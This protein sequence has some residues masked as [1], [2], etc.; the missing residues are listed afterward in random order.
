[1]N[2]VFNPSQKNIQEEL[3]KFFK[4]AVLGIENL[5]MPDGVIDKEWHRLLEDD[6]EYEVF[7]KENVNAYV[8]H[9]ENKGYG[10]LSWVSKYE[11]RFGKLPIIWFIDSNK[12]LKEKEYLNYTKT[13]VMEMAW[14]CGP[15]VTN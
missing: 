1:M 5:T 11:E 15:Y 3:I 7:C 10:Q 12:L 13:G 6:K 9:R 4:L 2:D 8:G 14:D